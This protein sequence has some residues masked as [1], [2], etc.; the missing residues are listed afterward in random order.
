M[1]ATETVNTTQRTGRQWMAHCLSGAV[2]SGEAAGATILVH[3]RAL[4][5]RKRHMHAGCCGRSLGMGQDHSHEALAAPI[6]IRAGL[7]GLAA[8]HW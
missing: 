7:K 2:G 4:H 3:S 1:L 8:P 5:Q 6:A